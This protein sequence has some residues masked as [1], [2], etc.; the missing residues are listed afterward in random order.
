MAAGGA[1]PGCFW[2]R[3]ARVT[4]LGVGAVWRRPEPGLTLS[5]VTGAALFALVCAG[6][7]FFW[8]GAVDRAARDLE[9]RDRSVR[10]LAVERLAELED[11]PSLAL[12]RGV[13]D[14]PDPA[15][16]QAGA[17]VLVARG[18]RQ[19][20][21][22]VIDWIATGYATDRAA[23]LE[24][25]R[26][27]PTLPASA[28]AAVERALADPEPNVRLAAIEVLSRAPAEVSPSAVA[29]RLDDTVPAVRL[30]A[31]RLL[32]EARDPRAALPLIERLADAD[33][34][35]QREAIA[36]LAR[37]GDPRAEPAL[38]RVIDGGSDDLRM[39]AVDA[40]GALKLPGAVETLTDI[41]R[42]RPADALAR[43]A[44]RSLGEIGTAEALAVLID[45]MRRPPVTRETED[46]LARSATML[47]QLLQ[48]IETGGP[49][50]ASAAAV[51]GR[52]REPRAVPVLLTLARRGGAATAAAVRALAAIAPAEAIAALVRA[53]EDRS[54]TVRRL[55]LQALLALDDERASAVLG[56]GLQDRDP[57]V[58]LVATRLAGRLGARAYQ[59]AVAGRLLDVSPSI[60]RAA[61]RS[62][63]RLEAPGTARALLAALPLLRGS[64]GLVGSALAAVARPADLPAL[65]R[66]ARTHHGAAR[67]AVLM[68]LASALEPA[69]DAVATQAA[70]GFLGAELLRG[71]ASA[72]LAAE[73]VAAAGPAALADS[74][75]LQVALQA[76]S[77]PVRARLCV[78]AA[79]SE[80]GRRSLARL[81]AHP[82]ESAE[83]QAAAA[84]ALGGARDSFARSALLWATTSA[85]PA[86]A[87][88]A[89]AARKVPPG[90]RSSPALRLRLVDASGSPEAGRWMIAHLPVGPVWIRTGILGQA[91]LAAAGASPVRLQAAEG[92]MHLQPP[93]DDQ[94]GGP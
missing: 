21:A 11:E 13:L 18:D 29:G 64:E 30:A 51:L 71:G 6:S 42:R 67:L 78:A 17:R 72:E 93:A 41:A 59:E 23:G 80:E 87:A 27:L 35:I 46:G 4:D 62:L 83:V 54:A 85:H 94:A 5:G 10:T 91:R 75:A 31:V 86:V 45:L 90:P 70:V 68:G 43:Q 15:L 8:P 48:E 34:Q 53:A 77:A 55:A 24:A 19:G 69:A 79:A 33:R 37:L 14:D 7:G 81:L 89:R 26:L 20:L 3:D 84:W 44:Q 88:N 28:R 63:A 82:R 12:L 76:G 92:T 56:A 52:L 9:S 36:A 47:P 40:V 74:R 39:A 73:A 50:A 32:A 49:G 61:V 25:L 65:T 16:R 38:L 22:V 1:F 57:D 66:A 58:R 60:R 2:R